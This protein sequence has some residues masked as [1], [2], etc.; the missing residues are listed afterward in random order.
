[1][2]SVASPRITSEAGV[3]RVQGNGAHLYI[4]SYIPFDS[5]IGYLNSCVFG[6]VS[7]F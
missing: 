7:Q 5:F 1:M 4:T 2:V 3:E 6:V